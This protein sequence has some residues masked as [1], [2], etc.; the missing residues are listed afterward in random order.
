M[1]VI[2]WDRKWFGLELV[3]NVRTYPSFSALRI[4]SKIHW[5]IHSGPGRVFSTLPL[6][7]LATTMNLQGGRKEGRKIVLYAEGIAI[8]KTLDR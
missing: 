6:T 5:Q 7:S 4:T 1:L 2:K 8:W 3:R